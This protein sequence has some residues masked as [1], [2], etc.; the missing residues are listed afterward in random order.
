MPDND[1]SDRT[2]SKLF[3]PRLEFGSNPLFRSIASL[4]NVSGQATPLSH[5][6]LPGPYPGSSVP[7][8]RVPGTEEP[9]AKVEV[10]DP[11]PVGLH[12]DQPP[13]PG[14]GRAEYDLRW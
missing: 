13:Q 7:D 2:N 3:P 4:Q 12:P 10:R 6:L 9:E 11:A 14:R 1:E 5:I 8:T